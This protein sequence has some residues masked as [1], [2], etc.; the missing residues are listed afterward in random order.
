MI[1]PIEPYAIRGVLWYQG[2][3]ITEGLPL[4]PVVM[5]HVITSWRQEWRQGDFPFYF[6]QLAAQDAASN[7]PEVREAQAR[8][9]N[10]PN[11]AMAVA[12]DIGE[13][14]NVHPKN[15]QDLAERLARIARAKVYG[16]QIEYS[17]PVYESMRVEGNSIRVRFTHVG[18]GLAAKGG[19]LKWLQVAGADQKFVAAA[20][21]IDGGS[22]VVTA[23][24]VSAPVA[25]RYAW[26]RW[27]DGAN[28]YNLDGLPAP[29]FR[30]DDWATSVS[31]PAT[32]SG[33]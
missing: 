21:R 20:A 23:P 30:S 28:L 16:E 31:S 27:P 4:Y 15:K 12:M 13:K 7:R 26:H 29:Q 14:K 8:A 19:E 1:R 5:E 18:R 17:G 9:L 11:T 6:V 25:V 2:E 24:G 32:G 10:L 33:R 22:V 3:S